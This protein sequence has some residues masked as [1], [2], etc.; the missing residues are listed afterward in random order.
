MSKL[1]FFYRIQPNDV[2]I[3]QSFASAPTADAAAPTEPEL[4]RA[5]SEHGSTVA[6]VKLQLAN[7]IVP[8]KARWSKWPVRK[9]S[10]ASC[11]NSFSEL[12]VDQ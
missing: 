10:D 5:Y 9:R 2:P 3:E 6:A 4:G 11:T 12:I 8:T 1:L 7:R